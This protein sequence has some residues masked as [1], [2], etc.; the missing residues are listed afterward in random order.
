M[1]ASFISDARTLTLA[2]N[3]PGWP[4]LAASECLSISAAARLPAWRCWH[5]QKER[6]VARQPFRRHLP[7]RLVLVIEIG[8]WLAVRVLHDEGFLTFLDRPGVAGSGC[9]FRDFSSPI[10]LLFDALCLQ[11]G[12]LGDGVLQVIN[13]LGLGDPVVL[14]HGQ[15]M[16]NL[17]E[18]KM[19]EALNAIQQISADTFLN[20]PTED[21]VA[22]LTEKHSIEPPVLKRDEAYIDG[23]HETEIRIPDYGQEIRLR[24][25]LLGL[26]VPYDGE[27]GMFY[28]NPNR[29]GGAP[30]ANLHYNNLI[31]TIKGEKLQIAHVNQQ[32]E[33]RLN[34][35]DEYLVA[36]R[37]LAEAHR[38]RL[39]GRLRPEIEARKENS[40]PPGRWSLGWLIRYTKGRTRRKLT[41]HPLSAR[42]S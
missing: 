21:I 27:G 34:E 8:K 40:L 22:A 30:R 14:F 38:D 17:T 1:A 16:N 18:G 29:Y 10:L 41:L 9:D 2:L 13:L 6:L 28:M 20:T 11:G 39:P 19:R 12:F 31:L 24:G 42:R 32:F 37:A 36:Q 25:T 3:R 7:L 33:A 15:E 35:I 26:I 23:P 4:N 5:G